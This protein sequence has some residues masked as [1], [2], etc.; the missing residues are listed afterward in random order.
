MTARLLTVA[1]VLLA[2]A[3]PTLALDDAHWRKADAAAERAIEYLRKSQNEDGSWTPKPGPA[4]TALVIAAMLDRPDIGPDD[5]TVKKGLDYILT[6]VK[7]DGGIHGGMLENY[8]TSIC[9]SALSRVNTRPD[10]AEAV[11]N[12]QN[13]LRNLQWAGQQG[14]DGKT[15]DESHPYYGGAGYGNSGR[16]DLSNTQFMLQALYDSGLDCNDP[17]FQ[18]AVVFISRL[19][20]IPSNTEYGDKIVQDG[21]FIY[22]TSVDKE[23]VGVPQ[24]MA[25]PEMTDEA[26]AGRPVSGL[27]TYGSVTYSAFKSLVYANLDRE[28]ERVK[29]V[30]N[31]V[32]RNY[33]MEQ[34]PGMPEPMKLQG[35]YYYYMTMARAMRAWGAST[36]DTIP[37]GQRDWANDL[38]AALVERQ[39]EDGSWVNAAD[40]WM[41]ADPNLVTAYALTALNA[42]TR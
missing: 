3:A 21:G 40:R 29:A 25:S 37:G 30:H 32:R 2:C 35:L 41:E 24:S 6:F 8:N 28:D 14:P 42:A 31:W 27:R 15:V 13:Y 9:L 36:I 17:A 7:P 23:R 1:L 18:R 34:N 22:T 20:G 16:P 12:A 11:A 5:P 33:T 38:I 4:I 39:N 19:Q 26:K 10:I